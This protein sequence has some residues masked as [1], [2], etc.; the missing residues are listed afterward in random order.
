MDENGRLMWGGR[1][2]EV[3]V[4]EGKVMRMWEG[5][6]GGVGSKIREELVEAVV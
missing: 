5:C 6:L 4:K 2:G 1:H 3:D